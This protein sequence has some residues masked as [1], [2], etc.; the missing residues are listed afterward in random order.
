MNFVRLVD[1][2]ASR[3]TASRLLTSEFFFNPMPNLVDF[4]AS[5]EL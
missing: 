3:T 4:Q 1:S 2:A 5:Y